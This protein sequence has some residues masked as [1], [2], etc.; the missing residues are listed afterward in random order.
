MLY[1]ERAESMEGNKEKMV[2]GVRNF[3]PSIVELA[4][5]QVLNDVVR[6]T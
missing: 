5:M 2:E 3:S 6:S 4:A 1:T